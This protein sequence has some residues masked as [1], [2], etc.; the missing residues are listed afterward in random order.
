[1]APSTRPDKD[2]DI[3]VELLDDRTI[4]PLPHDLLCREGL[5]RPLAFLVLSLPLGLGLLGTIWFLDFGWGG[6]FGWV[7]AA[8]A[9]A[10]LGGC[11]LM[12]LLIAGFCAG[13]VRDALAGSNWLL[14]ARPDG[15]FLRFRSYQNGYAAPGEP[16]AVYLPK[17]EIAWLQ[18]Q[19]ITTLGRDAEGRE[20]RN[21]R[22]QLRIHLL[23]HDT[24]AFARALFA[25]RH[26]VG[27][28]RFGIAT[29]ARHYPVRLAADDEIVVD[30][31]GPD[32]ATRPSLAKLMPLLAAQFPIRPHD[33]LSHAP[34]DGLSRAEQ[35]E[36]L[37]ELAAAGDIL[38]AVK[39]AMELYGL[40]VT[41]AKS[42]VEQLRR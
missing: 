29:T 38:S 14:R 9:T 12:T 36:Q 27:R 6:L 13:A 39:I 17:D 37:A 5:L 25:E 33:S 1:M 15:L 31:A 24:G 3:A 7:M 18:A 4:Q 34:Y 10:V 41:Q 8:L 11:G 35:E 23:H 20:T 22:A 30:W 2:R 42:F 21:Q 26:R 28:R 16:A 40:D 19:Q 32:K